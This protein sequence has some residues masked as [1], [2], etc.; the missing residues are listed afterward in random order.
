[1][2]TP[3]DPGGLSDVEALARAAYRKNKPPELT[4]EQRVS[5]KA[6]LREM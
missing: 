3:E 5:L 6:L 2:P 1:M 4:N